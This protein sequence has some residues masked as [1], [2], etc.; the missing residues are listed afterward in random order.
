MP[1]IA[2]FSDTVASQVFWMLVFFGFIFFFEFF[3]AGL[4][5][6]VFILINDFSDAGII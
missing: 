5:P 4:D 1:Q 2:Q 6:F 3:T